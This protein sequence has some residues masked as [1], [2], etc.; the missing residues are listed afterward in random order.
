VTLSESEPARTSRVVH[1]VPA[2]FGE[3]GITGG[4]ERYAYE[5]ARHMAAYVPTTLLSFGAHARDEM[6]DNLRIRVLS[7][8]W[9]VRGQRTNPV[10]AGMLPE[11]LKATVIH[12]H[13]RH[14]LA[15]T[16]AAAFGRFAGKRVFVSDLGGGGW[17]LSAYISTANWYH[18]HLHL[19]E[20]SRRIAGQELCDRAHVILG[21][22]DASKFSP[23][24]RT[25]P[26]TTVLYVG[27][28]LPHKGIN[29]LIEAMPPGVE[30]RIIGKPYDAKYAAELER[31][32]AGKEVIFEN[33]LDDARLVQAYRNALCIVLPS[34]YRDMYGNQSQVPE[35]LGQ[36]L[37]EGM[38]CGIPA[39]CTDVASMPEIVVEGM[40][41][42]VVAP[43]DS[44]ALREKIEWLG[45]HPTEAALMGS[46][47]RAR[48]ESDFRWRHVVER[49][50]EIYGLTKKAPEGGANI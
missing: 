40:T 20:Y 41:G 23:G 14:I 3:E 15:S 50:L 48:I 29:Y 31:M 12:C 9:H 21:G 36:T 2:L 1:I 34:V 6:V 35:L 46:A 37:L 11:I 8:S 42:F 49:C 4:A 33:D 38:A 17:D 18:G 44:V 30:L 26:R 27:R 39:I 19:S 22:V 16:L 25:S 10:H 47:G 32:A 43:N 13:Q 5:L 7:G 45:D 28:I 24:P